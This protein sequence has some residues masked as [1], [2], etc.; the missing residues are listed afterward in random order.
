MLSYKGLHT[1][2]PDLTLIQEIKQ[3]NMLKEAAATD[4]AKPSDIIRQVYD[5]T[6]LSPDQKRLSM[7]AQRKIIKRARHE[8][9]TTE[10]ISLEA[11]DVPFDLIR[12]IDG[13]Q[14]Y[15]AHVRA[16]SHSAFVFAT[17]TDIKSLMH[18]KFWIVASTFSAKTGLQRQVLVI[19]SSIGPSH[20][21]MSPAIYIL[22]SASYEPLYRQ[23]FSKLK[24]I[25]LS[26]EQKLNPQ[27]ML[28]DF[29]KPLVNALEAE[30]PQTRQSMCFFHFSHHLFRS[31]EKHG[32]AMSFEKNYWLLQN[33][34][35]LKALAYLP[36]EHIPDAFYVLKTNAPLEL[37]PLLDDFAD[38][39]IFGKI[40]VN[41]ADGT[42]MRSRP[43]FPPTFWSLHSNILQAIPSTYQHSKDWHY[44][45]ARILTA[46]HSDPHNVF[47]SFQHEQHEAQVK[48]TAILAGMGSS[49]RSEDDLRNEAVRNVATNFTSYPTLQFLDTIVDSLGN[50][51]R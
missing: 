32:L 34:K 36:P 22:A 25:V 49:R 14:F 7:N 37:H 33:Y 44:R 6:A 15:Q 21:Q 13:S 19:H 43:Q 11:I 38:N 23:I 2:A 1:H 30:F 18:S 28:T 47:R 51:G 3:R 41:T 29:E 45:M 46:Y 9:H 31:V 42:P 26:M 17:L 35:R 48:L 27:L 24:E 39:Y 4:G 5:V 50:E 20:Q 8:E 16:D 12:A 10:T 40:V